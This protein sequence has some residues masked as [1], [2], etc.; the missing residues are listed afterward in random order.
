[1]YS[2]FMVVMEIL[3]NWKPGAV[4]QTSVVQSIQCIG[5]VSLLSA[6]VYG[7]IPTPIDRVLDGHTTEFSLKGIIRTPSTTSI[8]IYIY[9]YTGWTA[10]MDL[11]SIACYWQTVEDRNLKQRSY[12]RKTHQVLIS[13]SPHLYMSPSSHCDDIKAMNNFLPI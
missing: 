2:D 3:R 9:I 8:Y 6:V 7:N 5:G 12:Y 1:S 10:R 4:V 11:I 13:R